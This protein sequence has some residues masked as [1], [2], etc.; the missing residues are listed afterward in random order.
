MV[1]HFGYLLPRPVV[2]VLVNRVKRSIRVANVDHG[3]D[4]R[5]GARTHGVNGAT[6]RLPEPSI[7]GGCIG[8]APDKILRSFST[9]ASDQTLINMAANGLRPS[10]LAKTSSCEFVDLYL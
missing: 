3:G 6:F 1:W 4:A 10:L 7:I 5:A 2:H 9:S 8:T